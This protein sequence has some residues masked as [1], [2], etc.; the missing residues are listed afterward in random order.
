MRAE[1]ERNGPSGSGLMSCEDPG[2]RPDSA[3]QMHPDLRW[4]AGRMA[5]C[6]RKAML[7]PPEAGAQLMRQVLP[8]DL[9]RNAERHAEQMRN[10]LAA[11]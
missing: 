1:G 4:D 6:G 7:I 11:L 2:L 3:P 10:V 8:G 9:V 5:V